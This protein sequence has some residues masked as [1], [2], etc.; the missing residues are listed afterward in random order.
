MMK[1]SDI[2]SKNE[3]ELRYRRG[4]TRNHPKFK[5][6]VEKFKET[7]NPLNLE[8]IEKFMGLTHHTLRQYAKEL[9]LRMTILTDEEG[10]KWVAFKE[11]QFSA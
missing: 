5:K 2:R 6:I 1:L 4:R 9:N 7:G 3:D 10:Q 11:V 8:D